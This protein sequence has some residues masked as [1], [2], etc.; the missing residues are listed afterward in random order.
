MSPRK[1]LVFDLETVPDTTLAR[2][3][4]PEWAGL[5]DIAVR[6]KLSALQLEKSQGRSDFLPPVY[7]RI[8][9][10]SYLFADIEN[11]DGFES[12]HLKKLGSIG[13]LEDDEEALIRKFLDG[14][15]TDRFRLVSFNGLNFDLP[16]L[17]VRALK[18][19]IVAKWLFHL[20][21]K[22]KNYFTKSSPDFHEDLVDMLAS[23]GAPLKL[24]E[25]CKLIGLPGKM[26]VDGTWVA[27][28]IADGQLENVRNY[29]E[30]DVLN[31]YLLYLHTKHQTGLLPPE[32]LARACSQTADYLLAEGDTRPHLA[33][34]LNLWQP[35]STHQPKA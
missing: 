35:A 28:L 10:I 27:D 26:D 30:T 14:A 31:T 33:A 21:D 9:G 24:D 2:T 7:H 29:C 4:H 16:C 6:A 25:L 8:V 13:T 11:T 15:G 32:G 3:L 22:W 19:G 1:L 12:Y 23:R 5:E 34:F 17:R 20:A 18:Y